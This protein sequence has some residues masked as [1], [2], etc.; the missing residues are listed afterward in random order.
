MTSGNAGHLHVW[1]RSERP[2]TGGSPHPLTFS[3]MG[4]GPA[5]TADYRPNLVRSF[6]RH[7]RAENRSEHT[8][9]SYLESL[10]QAEAFLA[11]R[12]RS[13]VDARREDLE[14]FLGELL[15]RRAAETVA[16]RYRRLRVL[17]R[18]LEEEEEI[19]ASPMAGM[20]PPIVPDQPVPIVPEDGLRRLLAA[21]AGK[22]FGVAS[23][24]TT[25]DLGL[26]DGTR[27]ML[28]DLLRLGDQLTED[29]ERA[30]PGQVATQS[31]PSRHSEADGQ[32]STREPASMSGA[33][34]VRLRERLDQAAQRCNRARPGYPPALF[35]LH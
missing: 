17:Y 21:C 10:R 20:K 19:P 24:P 1:S 3:R 26:T 31:W 27:Q 25:S 15:Q 32:G 7:L 14:A 28:E 2:H 30:S 33:D 4:Y 29:P 11:G 34:H 22:D 5:M 35:N 13:L 18:W 16:T 12:G 9:A 23:W 6:E 8:I